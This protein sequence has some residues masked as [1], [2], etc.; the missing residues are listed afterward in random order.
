MKYFEHEI[1]H[2]HVKKKYYTDICLN[3]DH[4]YYFRSDKPN[5]VFP[6]CLFFLPCYGQRRNSK[7]TGQYIRRIIDY[8]ILSNDKISE[9][10]D[11]L[12]AEMFQKHL[13]M[14]P[15]DKG[16]KRIHVW[17]LG[18]KISIPSELRIFDGPNIGYSK[19]DRFLN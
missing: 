9:N 19:I 13:E 10:E 12:M 15:D 2:I 1:I 16:K 14:F 18:N 11:N 3:K 7:K 6:E 8:C 5:F 17:T 4:G